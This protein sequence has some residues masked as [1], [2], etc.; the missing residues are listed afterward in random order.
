MWQR[1]AWVFQRSFFD[2]VKCTWTVEPIALYGSSTALIGRSP[3]SDWT[4]PFVIRSHAHVRQLL[5]HKL[6]RIGVSLAHEVLIKPLPGDPLQLA[7]QVQLWLL[8][9]VAPLGLQQPLGQVEH[10]RRA[11]Q[12]T[13]VDEVQVD[14]FLR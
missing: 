6:C 1:L 4:I 9:R 7:E 12:I 11:P 13:R 10:Q 8:A 3:C 14:P 5:I 2:V